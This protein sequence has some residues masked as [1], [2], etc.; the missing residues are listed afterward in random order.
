MF[1]LEYLNLLE[2]KMLVL[3]AIPVQNQDQDLTEEEQVLIVYRRIL[4]V[5]SV[6][7]SPEL[8]SP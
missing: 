4:F 5:I 6:N 7:L 2:E 3:L 8:P 1:V